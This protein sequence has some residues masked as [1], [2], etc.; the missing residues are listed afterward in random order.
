MEK[1]N[2]DD[3]NR[4]SNEQSPKMEFDPVPFSDLV[5]WKAKIF[6]ASLG[7]YN[8]PKVLI[9][10]HPENPKRASEIEVVRRKQI[11]EGGESKERIKG[12]IKAFHRDC[13]VYL[14]RRNFDDTFLNNTPVNRYTS[15]RTHT[16]WKMFIEAGL[17]TYNTLRVARDGSLLVTDECADGS[18]I[19]G[20]PDFWVSLRDGK[21]L[22]SNIDTKIDNLF[23]DLTSPENIGSIK[24]RADEIAEKATNNRINL[25]KYDPLELIVHPNGLWDL[26][27]LDVAETW[28]SETDYEIFQTKQSNS[29]CGEY[30]LAYLQR[31]RNELLA[32][33]KK[34]LLTKLSGYMKYRINVLR[35]NIWIIIQ[36]NRP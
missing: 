27:T 21:T 7:I 19:Y 30:L 12:K 29:S 28:Q 31:T 5:Y 10:Q 22:R 9:A 18:R 14:I 15:S 17:P 2:H 3:S 33:Q 16:N 4:Q 6:L 8:R 32:Y 11:Q 23:I 13:D 36:T 35:K 25:P 26:K 20:N 1:E 24:Q 34:S